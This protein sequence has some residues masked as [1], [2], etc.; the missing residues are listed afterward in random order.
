MSE[1]DE[2]VQQLNEF[3]Q[4]K[5]DARKQYEPMNLRQLVENMNTHRAAK[6]RL[7]RDLAKINAFYDVLR[8]ERVPEQM[9]SDGVENVRYE[10]IGL[11][12]LTS[13]LRIQVRDAKGLH[14]WLRARK[15]GSLIKEGVN[16]STLKASIKGMLKAGKP[17]PTDFVKVDP[18]TRAAITKG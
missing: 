1:Q 14:L 8:F 15:L 17:T 13:D 3:E 9:E 5:A 12:T 2:E 6:E 7:E 16:P 4:W 11:V 10:G 18:I